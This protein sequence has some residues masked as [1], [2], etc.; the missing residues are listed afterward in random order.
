MF[1]VWDVLM[2]FR[3]NMLPLSSESTL[4]KETACS[5]ET[6]ETASF[7]VVKIRKNKRNELE[8]GTAEH[9]TAEKSIDIF[10]CVSLNMHHEDS[11][12]K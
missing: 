7:R 1:I 8:A 2:M 12:K 11:F 10:S 9:V 3:R 6:L 4:K 5:K